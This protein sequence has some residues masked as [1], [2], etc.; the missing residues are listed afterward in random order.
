[1]IPMDIEARIQEIERDIS[2]MRADLDYLRP[3]ALKA[4]EYMSTDPEV[5]LNKARRA[6]EALCKRLYQLTGGATKARK[7]PNK[8]ELEDLMHHL[9]KEL[10]QTIVVHLETVQRLGNY[11]SHDHGPDAHP[12]TASDALTCLTALSPAMSWYFQR[13]YGETV[14]VIDAAPQ[15]EKGSPESPPKPPQIDE[16]TVPLPQRTEQPRIETTGKAQLPPRTSFF[17][18]SLPQERRAAVEKVIELA[19][20]HGLRISLC[21]R[22]LAIKIREQNRLQRT[23]RCAAHRS[24]GALEHESRTFGVHVHERKRV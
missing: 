24:N 12:A 13:Y 15:A 16:P 7:P 6:G 19:Q 11:G 9:R 4:M 2:E 21:G 23:V 14:H 5:S 1:M 10:P 20:R 17:L 18:S 8:L 3:L 22:D